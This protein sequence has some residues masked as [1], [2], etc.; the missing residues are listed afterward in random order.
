M[1][2]KS[3]T[4]KEDIRICDFIRTQYATKL[5]IEEVLNI[6]GKLEE[7]L[8]NSL[9]SGVILCYLMVEIEERSIPRIQENTEI[10]FKLKENAAFFIGAVKEYGVPAH[11]LFHINDLWENN[12]LHK[13]GIMSYS[14]SMVNVVECLATLARIATSRNFRVPLQSV[15]QEGQ[16]TNESILKRIPKDHIATLKSQLAKIK[17]VAT[18]GKRP[19]VS[20]AIVR[21]KLA[22][23]AGNGVDRKYQNLIRR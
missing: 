22:L 15:K 10:Q 8:H 5:W 17:E 11:K 16:W 13:Y 19:K 2:T 7:N 23:L 1:A 6:Q 9:K 21:R 20:E 18:Q 14:N 4:E 3:K 12:R